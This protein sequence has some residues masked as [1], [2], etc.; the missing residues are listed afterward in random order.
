[1]I[2]KIILTYYVVDLWYHK[3]CSD[4]KRH[5]FFSLKCVHEIP[6]HIHVHATISL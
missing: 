1:M 5:I 2:L 3:V 4:S 6:V